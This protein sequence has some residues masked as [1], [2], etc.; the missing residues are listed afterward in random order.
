MPAPQKSLSTAYRLATTVGLVVAMSFGLGAS[1]AWAQDYNESMSAL[2]AQSFHDDVQRRISAGT[3]DGP[4][5][6]L[7]GYEPE[8]PEQ[9]A[10]LEAS[11][12]DLEI[13]RR[14][15]EDP[16]FARYANGWWQ[17]YQAREPAEPGEYCA[18]AY[19]SPHGIITLTGHDKSWD[20]GM[21]LF[22]GA[23]IARPAVVQQ[24]SATLSQTGDPP[25]TVQAFV[26]AADPAMEGLGTMGFAVP[27]IPA[28]LNGMINES[29]FVITVEGQEV[30]RM[31]WKDGISARN[32]LRRCVR[33]R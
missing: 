1:A 29:E 16:D 2:S 17:F 23:K 8:T 22:T 20:G 26:F 15:A 28:A 6:Y 5:Y 4:T 24:V 3:R 31:S 27:S 7:S 10:A 13:M 12:R 33:Q 11:E 21:I 30:F 32:T 19:L 9:Q 18:A 14:L 25:A